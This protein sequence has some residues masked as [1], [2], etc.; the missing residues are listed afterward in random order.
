MMAC[1]KQSN[2]WPQFEKLELHINVRAQEDNT[3]FAEWLLQL[4]GDQLEGIP[5]NDGNTLIPIPPDFLVPDKH[6]LIAKAFEGL[7]PY[8]IPNKAIL[9]PFNTDCNEINDTICEHLSGEL[10][11]Y[12][13][14]DIVV[15]DD[16]AIVANYPIE[17][18]NSLTPSGCPP[19]EVKLKEG[20]IVMILRNLNVRGGICNGI[21]CLIRRLADTFIEVEILSNKGRLYGNRTFIPRIDFLPMEGNLPLKM[22]RRQYP[23]R[24]VYSTTINKNQDQT[25]DSAGIYLRR[26]V[27]THG[28]L[29]VAFSRARRRGD[30]SVTIEPAP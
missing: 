14:A 25:F 10:R 19:H 17:F 1:V 3:G 23:L 22:K 15:E 20:I 26:P 24:V 21:R 13:T 12:P 9:A 27:F 29:Y 2:I 18:L 4:G 30:I 11:T 16:D 6:A 28:Q 7:E 8:Q 5:R